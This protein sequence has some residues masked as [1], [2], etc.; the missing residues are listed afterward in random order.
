MSRLWDETVGP[1]GVGLMAR[2]SEQEMRTDGG[3]ELVECLHCGG[4]G[5]EPFSD[6]EECRVCLGMED[7]PEKLNRKYYETIEEVLDDG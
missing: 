2:N 4:S 1:S 6:G 3:G 7:V 5:E